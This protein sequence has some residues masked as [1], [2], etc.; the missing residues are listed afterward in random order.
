[1]SFQSLSERLV[2]LQESNAQLSD[3][4]QRLATIRF[5]PGSIPL[6]DEDDNVM[7]ELTLEIQQTFKEQDEDL[8]L[9]HLDVYNLDSGREG[10]NLELQKNRLDDSVKKAINDLKE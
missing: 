6:D 5:Q 4:I 9:L 10:G 2:A 7:T 8:E 1:M 3:L